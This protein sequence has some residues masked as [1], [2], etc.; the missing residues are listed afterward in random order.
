MRF[1]A[2]P[3]AEVPAERFQHPVFRDFASRLELLRGEA[4]PSLQQ[5][6]AELRGRMHLFADRPLKF[7]AQTP[8]LTADGRHYEARIWETGQ[9]AT[10]EQN[11]HD[12]FNALMWLDRTALKSAVNAAYFAELR[13]ASPGQ[14]TR[15]QAALTHFDEAGALVFVSDV[16]LM[17]DWDRHAWR[18]LL[19]ERSERWTAGAEVLLFGHAL[20]EHALQPGLWPVAKCLVI[21]LPPHV[22]SVAAIQAAADAIAVGKLL[23]DPQELRPLPLAGLPGWHA[24]AT[25]RRFFEETPC[26]RQA[27]PGRRYPQPWLPPVGGLHPAGWLR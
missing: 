25:S 15:A 17:D 11:W 21:E 2:P 26:F 23:R 3:R 14:R 5:L 18:S 1:H 16:G 10:R 20:L 13:R 19:G 12:L 27:K 9:I 8:A 22:G 6:N 7:V 4:W 24:G